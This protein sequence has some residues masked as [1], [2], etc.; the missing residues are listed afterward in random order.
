M[1]EIEE[2]VEPLH[3]RL[4]QGL[5]GHEAAERKL[6]ESYLSGRMHHAWILG[7][8][9]GIGKATLAYRFATFVLAN[10]NPA[11]LLVP[12]T[13]LDV[14]PEDPVARRVV[15]QAHPDLLLVTPA[16]DPRNKRPKTE[17]G[18]AEA[19][20]A[21]N[22]FARTAGEGGWRVCIVDPAARMNATAANALLKIL[23]E[24]PSRAL[25][26]LIADAPGRLLRTIRSRCLKLDLKPLEEDAMAT[27][28]R[29]LAARDEGFDLAV[30]GKITALAG[31]SPGRAVQILREGGY[32]RFEEFLN[33]A[34]GLPSLNRP[35]GLKLAQQLAARNAAAEFL[36]FC[37][38]LLS[39]LPVHIAQAVRAA[40]AEPLVQHPGAWA[41]AYDEINRSLRQVDALNL[42][43]QAAILSV[44]DRLARAAAEPP[45]T[46][47]S[48]ASAL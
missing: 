44:L 46:P 28:L 7:G 26:L 33:I 27:V 30:A 35:A 41:A 31:G 1:A 5:Q 43:K 12:P 15:A 40:S 16:W 39:W 13:S 47:S 45:P 32:K 11:E 9:G 29:D 8:P 42:D 2:D 48:N 21:S 34:R 18:V 19:R 37:E 4:T 25:F 6:L 24:P 20:Q 38:L 14:D 10:P 23:E 3:P 36:Q 17:I 22:F